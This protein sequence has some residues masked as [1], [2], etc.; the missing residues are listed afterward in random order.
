MDLQRGR[1]DYAVVGGSSAIFRPATSLA[2][3]RLKCGP[4]P[5]LPEAADSA[6]QL[7]GAVHLCHAS[8]L[9]TRYRLRRTVAQRCWSGNST[10]GSC[11]WGLQ[12]DSVP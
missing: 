5:P 6:G 1:V 2:F 10:R 4:C 11:Q 9:A 12:S 8:T 7:P 3:L